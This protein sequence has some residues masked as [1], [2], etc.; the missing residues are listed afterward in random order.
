VTVDLQQMRR[1]DVALA[2]R[3]RKG[4]VPAEP[5][6]DRLSWR[7]TICTF[8]GAI[9][10]GD[11]KWT[12]ISDSRLQAGAGKSLPISISPCLTLGDQNTLP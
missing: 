6:Q 3:K 5:W 10:L 8:D 2:R 9:N 11:E 12:S 1:R 7:E 4:N